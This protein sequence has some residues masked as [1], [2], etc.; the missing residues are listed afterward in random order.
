MAFDYT[1]IKVVTERLIED[2]GRSLTLVIRDTTPDNAAQP[3]RGPADPGTDIIKIAIGVNVHPFSK[4]FF[5]TE[6]IDEDGKLIRRTDKSILFAENSVA[7]FDMTLVDLL[8]D[9]S[10]TY[11]V[12]RVNVLDPGDTPILYE[13]DIK[14]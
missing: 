11:K 9:G 3:W 12:D 14:L 1:P 5:G 13:V 10:I 8:I 4:S 6:F 7:G 2:H